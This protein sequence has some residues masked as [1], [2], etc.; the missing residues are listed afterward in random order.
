M[1]TYFSMYLPIMR[2]VATFL[3]EGGLSLVMVWEA[4][5]CLVKVEESHSLT[6]ASLTVL[7]GSELT[8]SS[9]SLGNE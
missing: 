3:K 8:V 2:V 9:D 6:T 4:F 1:Q 7:S 5:L